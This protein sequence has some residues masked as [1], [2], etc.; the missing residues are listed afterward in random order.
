MEEFFILTPV[1]EEKKNLQIKIANLINE[2]L[3]MLLM[4]SVLCGDIGRYSMRNDRTSL[5]ACEI[6]RVL[7]Q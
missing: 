4:Y 1:L 3:W 2:L 6:L 7:F 5:S